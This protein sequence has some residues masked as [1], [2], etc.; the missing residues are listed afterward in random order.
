MKA[1]IEKGGYE[2]ISS[3]PEELAALVRRDIERWGRIIKDV[4]L[5]PQ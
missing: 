2:S 1:A 5:M 4:G 3:T